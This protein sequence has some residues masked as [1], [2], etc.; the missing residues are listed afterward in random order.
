MQDTHYDSRN[1][2][3]CIA[4]T[5]TLFAL[6]S[7]TVPASAF[8]PPPGDQIVLTGF[9]RDF[10]AGHPD[11]DV[12][13]PVPDGN[14]HY[15]GNV[16]QLLGAD[17]APLQVHGVT[18][19][20][21]D[22]GNLIPGVPY[23][24]RLSVLGAEITASG[25][26]VPVTIQTETNTEV[27]EPFGIYLDPGGSGNIND[28]AN[29]R[30]FI[31]SIEEVYSAETPISVTATSWLPSFGTGPFGN[32]TV[33]AS[34]SQEAMAKQIATRV[35]LPEDGTVTSITAY[36]RTND[37]RYAIYSDNGGEPDTLIVQTALGS[38]LNTAEWF[39][40]GVPD[41]FLT[42][43]TY[44]LALTH[45]TMDGKYRYENDTGQTRR[46]ANNGLAGFSAPWGTSM[47]G[48]LEIP[49]QTRSV[50]IYASYT[51][52]TATYAQHLT[53]KSGDN[54][55]QVIVLRNGSTVPS[56][57]AFQDQT[58]LAV[59]VAPYVNVVTQQIVLQDNQAIYLFELGTSN[60]NSASADFQDLV[61][62]V[63]LAT[64]PVYFF[65]PG[66][67]SSGLNPIGYKVAAQWTDVN[68]NNIAPHTYRP[69]LGDWSGD[70]GVT[71]SGGVTSPATYYEWFRDVLGKNMGITTDISLTDD[72]TGVYEFATTNF[73]PID[74]LLYGNEGIGHNKNFTFAVAA[75]FTYDASAGQFIDFEGG[76][77]V[78]IFI[79]G[80]LVI[81]LGGVDS[82]V[83]QRFDVDRL[84]LV[85]GQ[86]SQLRIF[87]ANRGK[88]KLF[89]FRTNVFLTPG[90][91][92]GGQSGAFD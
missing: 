91:I 28:G 49:K 86:E 7:L 20:N 58:N 87:Y 59:F 10:L 9:A 51:S 14:G 17:G 74:G 34:S 82:G 70:S 18:D 72:G 66:S 53:A 23:A 32:D 35:T 41:T 36:V 89:N 2:L 39:T 65:D 3:R 55:P 62:M 61:I 43:G 33:Y 45:D 29:P 15:A 22:F 78:W 12:P 69:S 11:F 6:G 47:N 83:E 79:D 73:Y 8:P 40:M 52:S 64:D 1:R 60:L 90:P 80:N 19:F 21:I 68:G 67:T 13:P 44:W 85:D 81:D 46:N 37:I 57:P 75:D 4:T 5:L 88:N 31:Y 54:S 84:G 56:I 42:A 92:L 38:Q 26:P 63:T 76:D 24:A 71:S 27:F 30:H 77:G 50:S 48:P 25:D 16:S